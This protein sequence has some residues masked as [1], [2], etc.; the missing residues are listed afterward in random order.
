MPPNGEPFLLDP[1]AVPGPTRYP[2]ARLAPATAHR[3]LYVSGIACR[4]PDG[5]YP[6]ATSN[7]DGTYTFDISAQTTAVLQNIDDIIKGATNGKG[8]IHNVIDAVVYVVDMKRDYAGMN[9]SWN[10]VFAS[11]EV[12]PARATIGAKELP[13][14]RL[15]VE[16]KAVAVVDV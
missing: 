16:V 7:A 15:I 2:H 8:G 9:E 4:R 1:Q 10:K 5:T 13:D 11:R 12:A 6:G 14:E 3:T